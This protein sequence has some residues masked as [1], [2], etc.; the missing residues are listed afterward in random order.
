MEL[1]ISAPIFDPSGYATMARFIFKELYFLGFSLYLQPLSR[2]TIKVNRE[3]LSMLEEAMHNPISQFAPHLSIAIPEAFYVHPYSYNIGLAMIETTGIP[4]Y[5]VRFCN[6]MNEIWVPAKNSKQAFVDSGV[7][8]EKVRIFPL[9]VDT[10]LFSPDND[11]IKINNARGF[12]FFLNIEWIPRKC[13]LETVEAFLKEFNA[14]EDVSLTVKAYNAGASSKV[15]SKKIAEQ[16]KEI[17]TKIGKNAYPPIILIPELVDDE[18]MASL[19][20]SS[21]CVI[22][23]SRGEGWGMPIVEAMASGKPY[24]ATDCTSMSEIISN[25]T[26]YKIKSKGKKLVPKMN[27]ATDEIYKG[28]Y[29][30]DPDFDELQNV[31]RYI[32][33]HQE[34]AKNKGEAGRKYAC[35]NLT[36]EQS[37]EKMATRLQE[38][39]K[40]RIKSF[41]IPHKKSNKCQDKR[42]SFVVSSMGKSCSI[43]DDTQDLAQVIANK[44]DL[45]LGI[46]KDAAPSPRDLSI[47][48]ITLNVIDITDIFHYQLK[49]SLYSIE[50]LLRANKMLDHK[51]LVGTWHSID[52][53]MLQYNRILY[54][55]FDKLVVHSKEMFDVAIEIGCPQ[56]KL[57]IIPLGNNDYDMTP[58][59]PPAKIK[60]IGSFGFMFPQKGWIEMALAMKEL[61]QYEW[62][63]FSSE[64]SDNSISKTYFNRFNNFINKIKLNNIVWND[65]YLTRK[66]VIKELSQCDL[67]VLPYSDYFNKKAISGAGRD[68]LATGVPVLV[69]DTT[70]FSDLND[71]VVKIP[72]NNKD[73]IIKGILDIDKD[74]NKRKELAEKGIDFVKRNSWDNIAQQYIKLWE[75]I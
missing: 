61:P 2:A 13:G 17:K 10:K 6:T 7:D 64:V 9:G 38:I 33:E 43:A 68:C 65:N 5:W 11:K 34:E 3:L 51:T 48:D 21:D 1:G 35:E 52:T 63:L 58:K 14:S 32:Y 24:I 4:K 60:T 25:E 53:E 55:M 36:W 15:S 56:N 62:K 26:G 74:V 50:D 73:D 20:Q 69:T 18:Y 8:E 67:I 70:F 31:M 57:T 44:T 40:T 30:D 47:D 16:T 46:L 22:L 19:Y 12:N 59:K 54:S 49:Y 41:I 39:D 27:I 71:E 72:T 45:F 37:V 66:E 28:T 42:I 75:E 23:A 29:W